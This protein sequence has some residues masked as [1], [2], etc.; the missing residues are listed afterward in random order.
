M[1][2]GAA[3]GTASIDLSANRSWEAAFVNDRARN[4]CTLSAMGGGRGTVTLS[5]M[6]E[7]GH[8]LTV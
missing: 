1:L 3:S 4:W 5:E 2:F 8:A 6:I 7:I